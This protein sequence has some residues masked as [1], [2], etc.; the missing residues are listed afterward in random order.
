MPDCDSGAVAYSESLLFGSLL[1]RY[2]AETPLILL[3]KFPEPALFGVAYTDV[4]GWAL[5]LGRPR[6]L[7]ALHL[8]PRG[9]LIGSSELHLHMVRCAII[10]EPPRQRPARNGGSVDCR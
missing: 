7:I 3:C 9:K 4:P 1:G 5:R 6:Q 2:Q 8:P 10:L